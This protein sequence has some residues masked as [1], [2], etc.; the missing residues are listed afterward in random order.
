MSIAKE[1]WLMHADHQI[2]SQIK[3]IELKITEI[4]Q[5]LEEGTWLYMQHAWGLEVLPFQFYNYK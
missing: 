2:M 5:L 4:F 3:V 1:E